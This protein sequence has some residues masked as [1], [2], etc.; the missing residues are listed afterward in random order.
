MAYV[1][2][3]WVR[4]YGHEIGQII[5]R[6]VWIPDPARL[7][8]LPWDE[9]R[10]EPGSPQETPRPVPWLDALGQS[11]SPEVQLV[12]RIDGARVGPALRDLGTALHALRTAASIEDEELRARL[13]EVAMQVADASAAKCLPEGQVAFD[14]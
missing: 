6:K 3:C 5:C 12:H 14:S 8:E 10:F 2:L 7:D 1:R 13:V 4:D 11:V 9:L